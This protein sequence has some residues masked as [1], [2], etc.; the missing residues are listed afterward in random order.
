[1]PDPETLE[2]MVEKLAE[3][4]REHG[5]ILL[6]IASDPGM[7]PETRRALVEHVLEEEDEYVAAM[8]ALSVGRPAGTINAPTPEPPQRGTGLTVGSLRPTPTHPTSVGSLRP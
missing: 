8:S 4:K 5:P 1:M 3:T 2:A 6:K 7:S